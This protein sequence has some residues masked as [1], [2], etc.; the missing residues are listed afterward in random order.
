MKTVSRPCASGLSSFTALSL[1]LV[2]TSAVVPTA[3]AA[4]IAYEGFNYAAG[5]TIVDQAGGFG[6]ANAWQLNGSGAGS[7]NNTVSG[8]LSYT[9]GLGNTLQT[10]GNSLFLAGNTTGNQT[11]QPNRDLLALRDT[12]TTWLSFLGYRSGTPTNNVNTPSNPYPR[13]ANVSFFNTGSERLAVGNSSGA[14]LNNWSLIPLGS[15]PN[16]QQSAF[17]YSDLDFILIKIEHIGDATVFDNAYMWVNPNLNVEPSTATAAVKSENLFDFSF[18]RVRPF[19]GGYDTANGGRPNALL[20]IDELRIG[21]LFADVTPY[22]VPEPTSVALLG[23]G[24]LALAALRR[25]K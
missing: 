13:G 2:L 23:V 12:G 24:A 11:A 6:F 15:G 10:S 20:N 3:S 14:A 9:D 7:I 21:E 1:G 25:R 4:L 17:S 8:S 19:A 16:I 18:N 5:G 22:V